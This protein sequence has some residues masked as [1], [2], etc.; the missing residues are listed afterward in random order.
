LGEKEKEE[1][2]SDNDIDWVTPEEP[3]VETQVAPE[4]EAEDPFYIESEPGEP[5]EIS[6]GPEE[7]EIDPFAAE[8][9]EP[10]ASFDEIE[11]K[12]EAE[13]EDE[14]QPEPEF[15]SEIESEPETESA[16]LNV[17]EPSSEAESDSAE[18]ALEG[19]AP[20]EK[21][22]RVSPV[23]IGWAA[24]AAS[25]LIFFGSAVLFRVSI[26]KALPG[27]ADVYESVG[28]PV[29][30]RGLEFNRLSHQWENKG[31]LMR[32]IVRGE[33]V[34]ITDDPV[35]MPEIVFA[36]LDSNGLEFFQW[37]ELPET[38]QLSPRGSTRFRAQIPAPADRVRQLKIRFAKR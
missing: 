17:N 1:A 8:E 30:V 19:D 28:L 13:G 26:S 3:A 9:G 31:G 36:M 33:I 12:S 6:Q 4:A 22:F 29:N 15:E 35:A 14:I 16:P 18:P 23:V 27:M 21:G 24:L 37:T 32:L 34:N 25:I 38:R 2:E 7:P 20:E 11:L 5:V 10:L